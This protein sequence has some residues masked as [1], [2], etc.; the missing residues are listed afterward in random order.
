M[1]SPKAGVTLAG[2][3]LIARPLGA[4]RQAQLDAVVIGK[5]GVDLPK[6]DAP[7]WEEPAE[8][9]HPLT[10]IV[11]GLERAERPLVVCACDLP[12]VPAVL[13]AHLARRTERLL[14]VEATGRMHPLIGRYDPALIGDLRMA[15]DEQRALNEVVYELGG[16]RLEAA[17]FGDPARITFNVNTPDDLR[18]AEEMLG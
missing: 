17:R 11:A 7:V 3:P 5:R 8:P 13:L 18:R 1:G 14:V 2:V 15:R 16:A 4:M 9:S 6:L 10:G 12:F